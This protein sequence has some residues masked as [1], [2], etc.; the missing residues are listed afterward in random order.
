MYYKQIRTYQKYQPKPELNTKLKELQKKHT[1]SLLRKRISLLPLAIPTHYAKSIYQHCCGKKRW[2]W[3]TIP[4]W[5]KQ[6]N[7][8]IPEAYRFVIS[9]ILILEL[10]LIMYFGYIQTT[11]ID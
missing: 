2:H 10:C 11:N 1:R 5:L 7:G 4:K 6:T 3:S 9:T 8:D